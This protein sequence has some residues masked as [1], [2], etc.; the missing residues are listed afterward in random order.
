MDFLAVYTLSKQALLESR[1][2]VFSRGRNGG[3]G[4][5]PCSN[6]IPTAT[7]A[8]ATTLVLLVEVG[9]EGGRDTV[10]YLNFNSN[11]IKFS[12]AVLRKVRR[13]F[14][15]GLQADLESLY[16]YKN[17]PTISIFWTGFV[18]LCRTF[19][20]RAFRSG[21]VFSFCTTTATT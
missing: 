11:R 1:W 10:N 4:A 16:R 14:Y 7:T 13:N 12:P 3:P 6:G 8:S 5:K 15:F 17:C 18:P 21:R 19:R 2:E 20:W 9:S